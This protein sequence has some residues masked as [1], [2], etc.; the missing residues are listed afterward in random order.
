MGLRRFAKTATPVTVLVLCAAALGACATRTVTEKVFDEDR[1]TVTLRGEQKGG[2]PVD[3]GYAHPASISPT[4]LAN[5]LSRLDLRRE[6]EDSNQH[7]PAVG[8]QALYPIAKGLS[9]ALSLAGPSQEI[10]VLAIRKHKRFG[11][12]DRDY[13]TSFIAYAKGEQ[14]YLHLSRSD[15][16]IGRGKND[17][18]PQP[19]RGKHPQDFRVIPSH[20]MALVDSQSVAIDW[21]GEIFETASRSRITPDG[22]VVRRTILYESAPAQTPVAEIDEPVASGLSATALRRLADLEEQ[23]A[24][25]QVSESEYHLRRREIVRAP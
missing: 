9:K 20:G 23:R 14:L 22:K 4:R 1:V 10:V 16:E 17:R 18:V 13:L 5:I 2:A 21:R 3:R 19:K 6:G 11:I 12:F 7:R 24:K 8:T 15:W 25:G